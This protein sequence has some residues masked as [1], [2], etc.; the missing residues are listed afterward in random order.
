MKT[1]VLILSLLLSLSSVI[2]ISCNNTSGE[3]A[4][5]VDGKVISIEE[6]N[7][8]YYTQNKMMANVDSNEDV[9]RLA[10]DPAY[11]NH[12]FL[13]KSNFLDHLIAQKLIYNKA[14]NDKSIDKDE[15]N[16][17]LEITKIQTASQYYLGKKLKDQI[18]VSEEEV[19]DFYNKNRRQFAGRTANEATAY[20][21]QQILSYK[22]R[23]EAN[24][25]VMELVAESE[26]KKE[27]LKEYLAKT[28]KSA[29]TENKEEKKEDTDK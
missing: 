1:R 23:Q 15:L 14:M 18:K 5:K 27:G 3:W 6:F 8:Y 11:A 24:Q 4:A 17:I 25:Y 2:F 10:N 9:D 19:A 12:P 13:N 22:S 21:R 7:K 28:K 26:V 20:I 29:D 16:T